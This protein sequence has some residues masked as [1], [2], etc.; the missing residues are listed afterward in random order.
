M[1]L[2]A[3]HQHNRYN[4]LRGEWILVSPHRAL[5]PW[6]GQIEDVPAENVPQ[7]DPNNPLCPGVI[8]ASGILTPKYTSTYV[9]KNDFP[10][11]LESGP[12]PP[13]SDDP[14]FQTVSAHGTCRVVCFHPRSDL[15]IATMT[16]QEVVVVVDTWIR[17][18]EELGEIY[19]W[20]QIFENRG[21]MMGCS[22]PH[23]HCQVWASSFL[24]NEAYIEDLHQKQYY[25]NHGRPLLQDYLQKEIQKVERIVWENKHWLIVVPYW[26]LWPFET[27]VLPKRQI[28]RMTDMNTEE[29]KALAQALRVI[30]AKYDN[31]FHCS[32][33]YSMGFHGAP[34]G[35]KLKD[36]FAY[37]TFHAKFL[38]PLLRSATIKKFMVGYELLA[39]AQRDLTA[40]KAAEILRNQP[41]IHYKLR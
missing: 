14:L 35:P 41:N 29:K 25:E 32:F 23:P 5:R 40:E 31:L 2:F 3:E 38:P 30:V 7:H 8:R 16:E 15:H 1:I 4:P 36:E 19:L 6:S 10:A 9:F 33:P 13:K 24:P 20:V 22:N 12:E 28:Q 21:A 11:L 27:L 34:T 17:Q 37:W 18:M 26:A 39:Q